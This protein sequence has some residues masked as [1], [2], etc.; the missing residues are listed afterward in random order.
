MV[1]SVEL[2]NGQKMPLLGLGCWQAPGDEV[3]AAVEA[4]LLAG[5]RHID[6]A[7]NYLN[8]D[9][10]GRGI[11]AA[12]ASGKIKRSD[13]FVVTKLPNIG[14]Q[15]GKV[16][17]F[18]RKSL[19]SLGL[20]YIDL[21]LVHVPIGLVERSETD[22]FPFENGKLL[23]DFSTDL[24]A[25]WKEMERMVSVGLTKSIGVSNFTVKQVRKILA[26]AKIPPAVQQVE[27]HV[28]FQQTEMREMCKQ[29]NIAFTSYS[30]LGSPGSKM[31]M[32]KMGMKVELPDLLSNPVVRLVAEKHKRTAAQVLLRFLVQQDIIVIPKSVKVERIK[33]NGDLFS[34]KL[35]EVDMGALRLLDQGEAG[36][37]VRMKDLFPNSDMHPEA[38][39]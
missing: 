6:T 7:Y 12:I 15:A 32:E 33:Q 17:K 27:C 30:S 35:D 14:M 18:L 19:K 22:V 39:H 25:I 10:V 24:I 20:D 11:K 37:I 28:Y 4:A 38:P 26:I 34:F 31:F 36:R 13:I 8:E 9:G 2:N 5:Y 16:E 23:M 29:H 3:A 1:P 21:Y